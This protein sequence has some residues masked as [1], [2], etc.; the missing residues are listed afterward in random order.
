MPTT[1]KSTQSKQRPSRPRDHEDDQLVAL[2][3]DNFDISTGSYKLRPEDMLQRQRPATTEDAIKRARTVA[4]ENWF[5]SETIKLKTAFYNYRP[6]FLAINP[7]QQAK[8]RDRLRSDPKLAGDLDRYLDD[9]WKEFL[10]TSSAIAF[11]RTEPATYPVLMLPE[12]SKFSEPFGQPKLQ[13]KL[14]YAKKD[15]P[16]GAT[17]AEIERYYSGKWITLDPEQWDEHFDVLTDNIRGRGLGHPDLYAVFQTLTQAE[18]MEVGE[19][20]LALA[21]RRILHRHR[22]G[23]EIRGSNPP[24]LQHEFATWKKRRADAIVKYYNGR[25]GFMDVVENFDQAIEVL[26]GDGGPKNYDEKKWGTVIR[27]LMWWAGPLGF[28]M[29]ANNMNPFLLPMLKAEALAVR[30]RVGHHASAVINQAFGLDIPCRVAWDN[31]CFVDARLAWDMVSTLLKQG[32]LSNRTALQEASFDPTEEAEN[33]RQEA[34][35]PEDHLPLFNAGGQG[36]G[37]AGGRP[38]EKAG[39]TVKASGH[40][41]GGKA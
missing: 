19:A 32:P 9:L 38:I 31:R 18:H 11:W 13:I 6:K 29:V 28:M 24:K 30:R 2:H 1:R 3:S 15:A 20:M 35:A 4:R 41:S 8:L 33:K 21:G 34:K 37:P 7:K 17:Q 39:G 14:E 12:N 16:A 22:L 27:R 26:L 36:G 5:V 25:Y 23:F 10:T 40:S